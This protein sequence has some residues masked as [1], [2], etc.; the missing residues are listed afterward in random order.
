[1]AP[2][3]QAAAPVLAPV[4]T[5]AALPLASLGALPVDSKA[6]I[7][8]SP[9][10]FGATGGVQVKFGKSNVVK[11]RPVELQLSWDSVTWS[12]VATAKMDKKGAVTFKTS[13]ASGGTYRA[14]AA[15]YKKKSEVATK[16]VTNL[17]LTR[18]YEFTGTAED[19]EWKHRA[20][21]FDAYGR[22]CAA[23]IESNAV[24]GGGFATLKL[25]RGSADDI[26]LAKAAG[27]NTKKYSVY[28]S[29]MVSTEGAFTMKTG[30]LAAKVK[31]PLVRGLH[32]G[33]W[34]RSSGSPSSEI[35]MVEA[36]G[37]PK[38]RGITH[39]WHY[40][41]ANNSRAI[42]EYKK[43]GGKSKSWWKAWHVYSVEFTPSKLVFRIDGTVTKTVS[44][45]S[46][47]YPPADSE[48]FLAM[49]ALASEFDQNNHKITNKEIGST[50]TT[51]DWV[52][53]W[54]TS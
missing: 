14:V 2:L 54:K 38:G 17:S 31:F 34:L 49:T 41:G 3:A 23:P 4:V 9:V 24:M 20:Q 48:Y 8:V 50:K 44:R 30:I 16:S 29:G 39:A 11:K 13:P 28:R 33:V 12:K 46:K 25:T 45:G 15:V 18:N 22:N 35:D 26:A 19:A 37:Y 27:C 5:P 47:Y 7:V 42:K 40:Y 32:N 52:R 6:T 10:A 1:M 43:L 36:Y 53:A 51:V 21:G